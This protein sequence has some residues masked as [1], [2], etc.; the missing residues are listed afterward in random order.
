MAARLEVEALQ[1]A[2]LPSGPQEE[3]VEAWTGQVLA[4]P[5]HQHLGL[6]A[7]LPDPHGGAQPAVHQTLRREQ[8]ATSAPATP[9]LTTLCKILIIGPG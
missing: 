2:S 5:G 3:E 8:A 9:R 6:Q 7:S 4:A 1:G